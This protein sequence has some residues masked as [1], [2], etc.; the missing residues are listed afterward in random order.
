M[1]LLHTTIHELNE[2]HSFYFIS[3]SPR[4]PVLFQADDYLNMWCNQ[5]L[6][7]CVAAARPTAAADTFQGNR[8]NVT[9]V[10]D[11]ITTLVEAAVYAKGILHKP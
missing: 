11:E 6:L 10:A 3:R 2:E 9:E 4:P 1:L 7:D 5:S 8:C